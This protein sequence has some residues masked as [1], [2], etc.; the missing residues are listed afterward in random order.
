MICVVVPDDQALVRAGFRK[1][2]EAEA[3]IEVVSEAGDG[4]EAIETVTASRPDVAL[5]DTRMPRLDGI[6]AARTIARINGTERVSAQD[7]PAEQIQ[8][9]TAAYESGLVKP[10]MAAD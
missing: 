5:L 3:D 4:R 1:I 6:E 7:V 9:V 10:G 8:A 2:L